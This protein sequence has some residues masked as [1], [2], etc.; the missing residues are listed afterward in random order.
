MKYPLFLILGCLTSC[1]NIKVPEG[2]RLTAA[3]F[4]I[5]LKAAQSASKGSEVQ[6]V[7]DQTQRALASV[8]S[9]FI[10]DA[11][12]AVGS[13]DAERHKILVSASGNRIAVHENASESSPDEQIVIFERRSHEGNASWHGYAVFPPSEPALPYAHYGDT[14]GISDTALYFRILK[15][16]IQQIE[17]DQLEKV[18]SDYR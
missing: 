6:L 2:S 11:L 8:P 7:D 15:G 10:Y 17:L 3:G 4:A 13:P 9:V 14:L 16:P 1:A 5:R 12:L 18:P